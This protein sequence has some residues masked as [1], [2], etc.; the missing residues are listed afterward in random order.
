M[1][2]GNAGKGRPKGRPNRL[3][4]TVKANVVAVFEKI[5]GVDAMAE[6][7]KDDKN[8]P[9]FY[10]IYS[11]L[12][13]TEIDANIGGGVRVAFKSGDKTIEIGETTDAA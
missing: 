2:Q 11:K 6:W 5:G 10:R 8:K 4:S 12:M 7:A 13:P 9:D 1:A 3:S